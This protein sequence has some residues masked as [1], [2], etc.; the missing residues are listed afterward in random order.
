MEGRVS[1]PMGVLT[2]RE[3]GGRVL[4]CMERTAGEGLYRGWLRGKGGRMDLGVLLPDGN[5]LWLE[6]RVMVESLRKRGCWPVTGAGTTLSY[7]FSRQP[8]K[9]PE[10]WRWEDRPGRLFPADPLLQRTAETAGRCLYR[11]KGDGFCLAYPWN[12]KRPFPLPPVFCFG[13]M[14]GESRL[15]FAFHGDGRPDLQ[16]FPPDKCRS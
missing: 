10:G 13:W 2:W 9:P 5:R 14:E 15:V 7:D 11:Q 4:L 1:F 12:V 16:G 3:Q 6:K 8:P